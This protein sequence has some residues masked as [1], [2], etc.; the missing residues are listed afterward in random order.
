MNTMADRS[1]SDLLHVGKFSGD[2]RKGTVYWWAE[3][4]RLLYSILETLQSLIQACKVGASVKALC[5]KGDQQ[6]ETE[7]GK[8]MFWITKITQY[9]YVG[10]AVCRFNGHFD[11][12]V[13]RVL[14]T[15]RTVEGSTPDG[16]ITLCES[17]TVVCPMI[18]NPMEELR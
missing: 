17:L 4:Y 10:H 5:Q 15:N 13:V 8:V 9:W 3:I 14:A 18:K 1:A 12:V 6:L 16:G 11:G 2:N 7:T